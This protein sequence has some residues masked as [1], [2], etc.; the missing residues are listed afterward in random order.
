MHILP[1]FTLNKFFSGI[2]FYFKVNN[3]KFLPIYTYIDMYMYTQIYIYVI[4]I[5]TYIIL[6]YFYLKGLQNVVELTV[7]MEYSFVFIL[8]FFSMDQPFTL[9]LNCPEVAP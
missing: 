8:L 7:C 9:Y 3:D 1:I 6:C 4:W 5:Y 2:D